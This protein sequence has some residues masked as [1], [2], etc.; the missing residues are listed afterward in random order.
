VGS[1]SLREELFNT[2]KTAAEQKPAEPGEVEAVPTPTSARN[3]TELTEEEKAKERKERKEKAVKEREREVKNLKDKVE[4]DIGKSRREV[5][6]E[7]GERDYRYTSCCLH[8]L[9]SI[10]FTFTA[11]Q[12]SQMQ[13]G[14]R[15]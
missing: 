1:S 9:P 7:E 3:T 4:A 2:Y 6:K 15:R 10:L 5:N 8:A 13:Y 14:T 11:G 12:C